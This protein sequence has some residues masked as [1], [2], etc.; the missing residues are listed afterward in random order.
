MAES[1]ALLPKHIT[2]ALM[3]TST[4]IAA[5]GIRKSPSQNEGVVKSI[6]AIP[7]NTAPTG[8][9]GQIMLYTPMKINHKSIDPQIAA[10]VNRG[11]ELVT[12]PAFRHTVTTTY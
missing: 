8:I 12:R 1:V 6:S 10:C 3:T 4:R 11:H 7:T 5:V 2:Y 9:V